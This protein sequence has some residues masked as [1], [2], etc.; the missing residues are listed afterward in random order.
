MTVA[1]LAGRFPNQFAP[2]APR[3]P[4]LTL[5]HVDSAIGTRGGF[6]LAKERTQVIGGWNHVEVQPSEGPE[7]M[8][9]KNAAHSDCD[10][11]CPLP[12]TPRK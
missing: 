3:N 11:Y 12:P 4:G 8:H 2:Q 5:N 7:K 9:E 6:E 10:R 1:R